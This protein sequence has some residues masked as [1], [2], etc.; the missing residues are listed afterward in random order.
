MIP[1]FNASGVLPPYVGGSPADP[2][3]RSPYTTTM[4][5]IAERMCTSPERVTL[6]RGL[7]GLRQALRA[8][9]IPAGLQWINGSFCEDIERIHGRAPGD[10]DLVTFFVRPPAHRADVAWRA[11]V[12]ANIAIFDKNATKRTYGCE[13]FYVDA[14]IT[15]GSVIRQ[16]AY[17][18]GLFTHQRATHLWKGILEVPLIVDDSDALAFINGLRFGP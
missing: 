5:E 12:T 13:S 2:H 3:G 9:G 14:G 4:R 8:L 18:Y 17:W 6:L 1:P 10:I 16:T 11:F 7:I 15:P